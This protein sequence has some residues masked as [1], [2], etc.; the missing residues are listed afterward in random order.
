MDLSKYSL[1]ELEDILRRVPAEIAR[2]ERLSKYNDPEESE[3]R[4]FS[5][6]TSLQELA[7]K[8]GLDLSKI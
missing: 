7:K 1:D 5:V 4:K 3:R 6:W 8:Q 2:Q